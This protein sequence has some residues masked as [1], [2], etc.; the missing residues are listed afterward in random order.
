M[1]A[2]VSSVQAAQA[3]SSTTGTSSSGQDIT[4]GMLSSSTGAASGASYSQ[5]FLNRRSLETLGLPVV[6]QSL[7]DTQTKEVQFQ[8]SSIIGDSIKEKLKKA[9]LSDRATLGKVL[10]FISVADTKYEA[11]V[12]ALTAFEDL[13]ATQ[14]V[15][16]AGTVT[17]ASSSSEIDS[18]STATTALISTKTDELAVAQSAVDAAQSDVDTATDTLSALQQDVDTAQ[19]AVTD[20]IDTHFDQT[21]ST[22]LSDSISARQTTITALQADVTTAQSAYDATDVND[23]TA[24]A[25]AQTTLTNAQNA[26]TTE[27][28]LLAADQ[29][30]LVLENAKSAVVQADLDR[31]NATLLANQDRRDT[32]ALDLNSKQIILTAAESARDEIQGGIDTLN[33]EKISLDSLYAAAVNAEDGL[34]DYVVALTDLE[35]IFQ[36]TQSNANDQKSAKSKGVVGDINGNVETEREEIVAPGIVEE[37]KQM[38][39]RYEDV[40]LMDLADRVG[41]GERLRDMIADK[42]QLAASLERIRLAERQGNALQADSTGVLGRNRSNSLET[43]SDAPVIGRVVRASSDT[44]EPTQD[45]NSKKPADQMNVSLARN[46]NDQI[47]ASAA[48]AQ[49]NVD[50]SR[51]KKANSAQPNNS[52]SLPSDVAATN[53]A[54]VPEVAIAADAIAALNPRTFQM[55]DFLG[56]MGGLRNVE[57][58]RSLLAPLARLD[59]TAQRKIAQQFIAFSQN[60][61]AAIDAANEIMEL[62][63]KL[64]N[65]APAG[66]IRVEM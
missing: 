60:L 14:S 6:G 61:K 51:V 3:R 39:R 59:E 64:E 65:P 56:A 2:Q 45:N 52:L 34:D 53:A 55:Q 13:I 62:S 46:V 7:D 43:L 11:Y 32:A 20:Y 40:R 66:R 5:L 38:A 36:Q 19:A 31:L 23:A 33:L 54:G 18:L 37:L 28:S 17:A 8:V 26:L 24:L 42:R 16:T 63:K 41:R 57:T 9:A 12:A 35:I 27:Q 47:D 1:V 29:A 44:P 21:R 10:A 49:S 48:R 25:A 22:A 15:F 50:L 4:G 30:A 58:D